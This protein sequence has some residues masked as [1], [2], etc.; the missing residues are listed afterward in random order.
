M[1]RSCSFSLILPLAST[2]FKIEKII[3][4]ST[5]NKALSYN[6]LPSHN[7]KKRCLKYKGY[8]MTQL[9]LPIETSRFHKKRKHQFLYNSVEIDVYSLVR[10]I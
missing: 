7:F 4:F 5:K 1:V 2:R 9:T 8:N 6:K 10:D 3:C